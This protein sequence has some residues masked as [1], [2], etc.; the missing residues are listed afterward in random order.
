M[1]EEMINFYQYSRKHTKEKKQSKS[2]T[3]KGRK[4]MWRTLYSGYE[5]FQVKCSMC[6]FKSVVT[7]YL[8][9]KTVFP[10]LVSLF[11]VFIFSHK[12]LSIDFLTE[13]SRMQKLTNMKSPWNEFNM[14]NM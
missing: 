13:S 3:I 7:L 5:L 2:R 11:V 14:V 6:L 1:S 4:K 9:L 12:I 10:S 8:L